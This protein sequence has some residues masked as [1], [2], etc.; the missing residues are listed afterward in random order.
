M[1]RILKVACVAVGCLGFAG[2]VASAQ[3]VIHAMTGTVRAIDAAQKSFTLFRDSGSLITFN[4]MVGSKAQI[5]RDEKILSDATSAEAFDKKDA[6]VIVFYYGMADNPTAVAVRALG[7]GPFTA[8]VGTVTSFDGRDGL[9]SVKD[10]SGSVH[11][12]KINA[13]TI[14]ESDFGVVEGF[15]IHAEKGGHIRIV[16]AVNKDSTTALFLNLM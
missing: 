16:G 15:K 9:I 13:D 7:T 2:A 6:Y 11:S 5:A 1:L 3:E 10:E 8:T 4:D 12:Y 14:A